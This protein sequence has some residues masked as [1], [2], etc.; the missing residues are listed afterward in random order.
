MNDSELKKRTKLF[1]LRVMK[2]VGALPENAV[3]RPIGNQLIRSA[4]SVGANYRAACRGRSKA[5]F[6]SKLSIV[7]EEADECC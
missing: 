6:V 7:I 4:T 3:G 2:L 5:E 1:A